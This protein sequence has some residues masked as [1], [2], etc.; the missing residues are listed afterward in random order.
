MSKEGAMLRCAIALLRS[1]TPRR[2]DASGEVD[3]RGM[4]PWHRKNESGAAQTVDSRSGLDAEGV[5]TMGRAL[6]ALMTFMRVA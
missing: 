2:L 1:D 5:G 3:S 6:L 4:R